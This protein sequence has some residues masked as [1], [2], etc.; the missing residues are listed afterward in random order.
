MKK[1]T[2]LAVAALA[3]SFASCKK[4]RTCT[5]TDNNGD[6]TVITMD[7]MSSGDANAACPK[8]FTGKYTSGSSSSNSSQTC[9]LS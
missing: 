9:V 1:I 2:I 4:A 6:K 8:T 3:V 5:C 7:K